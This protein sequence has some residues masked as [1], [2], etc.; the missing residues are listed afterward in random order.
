MAI[1]EAI[2]EVNRHNDIFFYQRSHSHHYIS[3]P[4]EFRN[5]HIGL[6]P[7]TSSTSSPFYEA[8][9]MPIYISGMLPKLSSQ[10]NH[11]NVMLYYVDESLCFWLK[12]LCITN[13][14]FLAYK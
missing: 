14:D 10:W 5:S 2:R 7:T 9:C 13:I 4:L 11:N 3:T 1:V 8:Y 6:L 12:S